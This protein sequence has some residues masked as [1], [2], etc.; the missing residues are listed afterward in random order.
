MEDFKSIT[1]TERKR[2]KRGKPRLKIKNP[3]SYK[4]IGQ[5]AQGAVFK[6]S[7]DRCVKIYKNNTAASKERKA[8]EA[9]QDKA[10]M[11]K[12]YEAGDNYIE[13]EYI[14][15]TDLI[16]YLEE[17]GHFPKRLVKQILGIL[18]DMK[19]IGFKRIDMR[20]RHLIV[21]KDERLKLVD[22]VNA[23]E[24]MKE[25]VRLLKDLKN[26]KWLKPF[27][28]KVKKIDPQRYKKWKSMT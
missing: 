25:P 28:K 1:V 10:F 5:G 11:P 13:M 12:L 27:L 16:D 14:R 6:L 19:N 17:T 24:K 15:G 7:S 22:H 18:D 20:L 23:Y 9:G 3:T 21:T 26:E 2:R 4:L 8:M